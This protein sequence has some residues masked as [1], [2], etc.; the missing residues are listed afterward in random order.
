MLRHVAAF[1]AYLFAGASGLAGVAS[2]CTD[3]HPPK[4]RVTTGRIEGSVIISN[5]LVSRR[6]RFRIY[7]DRGPGAQPPARSDGDDERRNVV[8]YLQGDMP[9][10]QPVQAASERP[11]IHQQDEQFF[12]HILPIVRGT[13]VDF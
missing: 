10:A 5:S 7:G 12:P 8:L 6:P 2:L 11:A 3:E 9:D 1:T 13:S 4:P